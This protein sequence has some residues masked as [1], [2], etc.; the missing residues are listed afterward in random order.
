MS[1]PIQRFQFGAV[2]ASVFANEVQGQ[3]GQPRVFHSVTID[4]V[5]TGKDGQRHNTSSFDADDLP[6][7]ALAASKAYEFVV[8][9]GRG[10]SF[11]E[12]IAAAPSA[13]ESQAR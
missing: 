4:K 13:S 10:H 9:L 6:K 12:R 8:G 3:D 5:Y 11:A 7:V 2:G 1:K